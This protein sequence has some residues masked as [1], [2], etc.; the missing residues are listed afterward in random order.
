MFY[1]YYAEKLVL[2]KA[3]LKFLLLTLN[4]IEILIFEST[5]LPTLLDAAS[6]EC[7]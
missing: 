6:K 5:L 1:R 7:S 3:W 4:A 2:S